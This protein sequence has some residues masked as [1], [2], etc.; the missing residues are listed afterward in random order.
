MEDPDKSDSKFEIILDLKGHICENGERGLQQA[1]I[2]PDF[3]KNRFIYL[4][5]TKFVEGCLE[6]V[7]QDKELHPYN[8][9]AR[10]TMNEETLML[11]YDSREE[12][13][14]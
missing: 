11:D 4:F 12:I 9:I 14:R 1:V 13:W 3:E 5:Y 10:F 8:V 2:H 7:T 6:D